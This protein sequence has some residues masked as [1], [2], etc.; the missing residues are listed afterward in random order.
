MAG[1]ESSRSILPPH[2]SHF[3]EV[4]AENFWIF[5]IFTPHFWHWYSK[6][7]KFFLPGLAP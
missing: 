3:A 4:G 7:G 1:E 5:S 6:S 2:V